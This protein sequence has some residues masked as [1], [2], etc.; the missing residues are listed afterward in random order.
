[1]ALAQLVIALREE[2]R[3]GLV[4]EEDGEVRKPKIICSLG[5]VEIS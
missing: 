1:M 2:D 3:L 5:L 4:H